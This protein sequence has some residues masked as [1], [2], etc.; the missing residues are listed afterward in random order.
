M[1][2][3]AAE[4][5]EEDLIAVGRVDALGKLEA[6][7]YDAKTALKDKVIALT[8]ARVLALALALAPALALALALALA[9]ARARARARARALTL[10]LTP[11]PDPT[12]AP[13]PCPSPLPLPLPL[14][15]PCA[16]AWR[17]TTSWRCRRSSRRPTGGPR[18]VVL[19]WHYYGTHP[20]G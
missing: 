12:P 10:S 1:V 9:P 8:L 14:P 18:T 15:R 7:I 19:L 5:N 13:Y 3:D 2:K 16:G 6:Y 17:R 20:L 4:W 11:T